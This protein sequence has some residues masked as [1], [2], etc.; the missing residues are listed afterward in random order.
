MYEV[1]INNYFFSTIC[2]HHYIKLL[3]ENISQTFSIICPRGFRAPIRSILILFLFNIWDNIFFFTFLYLL[4]FLL[5]DILFFIFLAFILTHLFN[6]LLLTIDFFGLRFLFHYPVLPRTCWY[7]ILRKK[8][9]IS[10][11]ISFFFFFRKDVNAKTFLK[12]RV[13]GDKFVI[14]IV[15]LA[16]VQKLCWTFGK[17][18]IWWLTFEIFHFLWEVHG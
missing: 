2:F 13:L 11:H 15:E 17:R 1:N 7:F 14:I 10:L 4:Y 9:P 5:P 12:L 6:K 3:S 18:N 8:I 16:W